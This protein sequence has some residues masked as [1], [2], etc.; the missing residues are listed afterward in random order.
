[1]HGNAQNKRQKMLLNASA[2]AAIG[3][4]MPGAGNF[5][6]ICAAVCDVICISRAHQLRPGASD[7]V[8]CRPNGWLRVV[9][10]VYTAI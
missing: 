2:W 7:A 4:P 9:F 3:A 10:F 8:C 5:R 6:N 1:M